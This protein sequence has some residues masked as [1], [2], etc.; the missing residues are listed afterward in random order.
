MTICAMHANRIVKDGTYTVD[1]AGIHDY[2]AKWA[3]GYMVGTGAILQ[4]NEPL[5]E[6]ALSELHEGYGGVIGIWA[7]TDGTIYVDKVRHVDALSDAID[8][9]KRGN[10][11]AIWDLRNQREIRIEA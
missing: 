10:E 4:T 7:D 8:L 11:L 3:Y 5:T 6:R 1:N 9:A 2:A